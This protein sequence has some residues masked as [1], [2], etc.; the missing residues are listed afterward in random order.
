MKYGFFTNDATYDLA[1]GTFA[2]TGKMDGSV[3]HLSAVFGLPEI[4]AELIQLI[5]MPGFER[6]WLQY[7]ELYNAPRQEQEKALGTSLRGAALMSAHSRLTAYAAR[8]KRDPN[9]AARA[10]KE[11]LG[12]E[13]RRGPSQRFGTKTETITG[14]AVLQPVDEAPWVSTNDT[15]QW[16]LSAIENLQLVPDALPAAISEESA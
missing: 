12:G 15:A 5:D 9:L 1:T 16:S 3:S 14:P 4:C 8:K 10:W 2:D 7:C 13:G 6:A 11:F